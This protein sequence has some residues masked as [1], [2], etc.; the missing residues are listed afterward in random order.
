MWRPRRKYG[1]TTGNYKNMLSYTGILNTC[2][3]WFG[4][5]CALDLNGEYTDRF[6]FLFCKTTIT[7]YRAGEKKIAW[8]IALFLW[9]LFVFDIKVAKKAGFL[10]LL[11]WSPNK[12]SRESRHDDL[13]EQMGMS[14]TTNLLFWWWLHRP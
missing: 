12:F 5:V 8:L 3:Y 14:L 13:M 11:D 9:L 2:D 10:C 4:K 6:S 7:T 1:P